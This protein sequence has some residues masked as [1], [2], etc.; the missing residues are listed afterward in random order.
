M[1]IYYWMLLQK[2][3]TKGSTMIILYFFILRQITDKKDYFNTIIC[4]KKTR[5]NGFP[6]II[7]TGSRRI[8]IDI[9]LSDW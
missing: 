3:E 9:T 1:L 4:A 2:N 5:M 6:S 8:N 7:I